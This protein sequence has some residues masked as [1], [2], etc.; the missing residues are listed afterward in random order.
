MSVF[1]LKIIAL[2]TML[3]DHS[4][5]ILGSLYIEGGSIP[6]IVFV[7]RL[8]GRIAFP[9]YAFLVAEGC[10]HTRNIKKYMLRLF[11]FAIISEI[12]FSL[13][14]TKAWPI[15][16]SS[17]FYFGHRNVFY[18]LLLG[19]VAIFFRKIIKEKICVQLP[20]ELFSITLAGILAYFAALLNTDYD[21]FGVLL[22]YFLALTDKVYTRVLLLAVFAFLQYYPSFYFWS[23]LLPALLIIFYNGEL[24][25]YSLKYFFY[26]IYPVHILILYIAY[27]LISKVGI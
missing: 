16:M 5:E 22:I 19:V 12:P 24:G 27:I 18:T 4:G 6:I 13:F 25:K 23:A 7:M 2:L 3:I 8:L 17:L 15:D 26:I 10:R 20:A 21:A 9:I 14:V 11:I 1:A